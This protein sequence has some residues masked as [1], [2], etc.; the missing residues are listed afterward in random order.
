MHEEDSLRVANRAAH[1]HAVLGRGA[2]GQAG[3]RERAE[4]M[5]WLEES[6]RHVREFL[7]H[8]AW[9]AQTAGIDAGRHIDVEALLRQAAGN[10]LPLERPVAQPAAASPRAQDMDPAATTHIRRRRRRTAA[11]AAGMAATV[12]ALMFAG[13][14]LLSGETYS[15]AIGELRTVELTD[16]STIQLSA[17]STVEV[18]F[19]SRARDIRLLTGEALFDVA[20]DATRPFRVH[21][22]RSMIQ[23]VGTRFTINRR[24]LG[25][26]VSVAEGAVRVLPGA[27]GG[28]DTLLSAGEEIIVESDGRMQRREP[29]QKAEILAWRD[30]RLVFRDDALADIAAEFNRHNRDLQLVIEGEPARNKRYGGIFDAN[31]PEAIVRFAAQDPALTIRRED[32]LIII[33]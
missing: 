33:R 14:Q 23:A 30:R 25:T 31:D 26:V 1:W 27:T 12:A 16:G 24:P 17:H 8:Q 21:A 18:G 2:T 19:S 4:F 11:V 22:G 5:A 7:L 6:P 32:G 29:V 9:E 20:P 15:T 10:V 13:W 28:A 3:A